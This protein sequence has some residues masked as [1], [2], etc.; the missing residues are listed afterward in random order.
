MTIKKTTFDEINHTSFGF[1]I[2]G[3]DLTTPEN[4]NDYIQGVHDVLVERGV[5][6]KDAKPEDLWD[7]CQTTTTGGRTDLIFIAKEGAEI[8]KGRLA[9]AKFALPDCYWI[10]TWK[11]TYA[12][13]YGWPAP[14]SEIE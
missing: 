6:A 2:T 4:C 8:D 3:C 10:E 1:V 9:T 7:T 11:S 12:N 5:V 14:L 13:H